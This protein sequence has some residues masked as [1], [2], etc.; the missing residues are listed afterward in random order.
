MANA[1]TI[2]SAA[3]GLMSRSDFEANYDSFSAEDKDRLFKLFY[4]NQFA[5]EAE[6]RALE[7][8]RIRIQEKTTADLRKNEIRLVK[9]KFKSSL[10]NQRFIE[11][12]YKVLFEIED[13][14]KVFSFLELD[15]LQMKGTIDESRSVNI[16]RCKSKLPFAL[17]KSFSHVANI[18]TI[19]VLQRTLLEAANESSYGWAA[20]RHLEKGKGVFT[21][22]DV[23]NMEELRKAEGYVRR[24]NKEK[25]IQR[26]DSSLRGRGR[27]RGYTR[28]GPPTK[29]NFYK[30]VG[31]AGRG[32]GSPQNVTNKLSKAGRPLSC[33]YCGET[34][35]LVNAC[36]KKA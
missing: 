28:W 17:V 24:D 36:P 5:K 34:S 3:A 4:V 10:L 13:I 31:S 1:I 15:V 12:I 29:N 22:E 19:L 33:F 26:N 8:E 27:R 7:E 32:R 21:V 18:N 11:T 6:N 2:A 30:N 14:V 16:D 25:K 23:S 20:A 9:D 35:H